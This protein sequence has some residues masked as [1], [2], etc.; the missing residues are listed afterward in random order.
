MALDRGSLVRWEHSRHSPAQP[1]GS[2]GLGPISP[3][4]ARAHARQRSGEPVSRGT[5]GSSPA[6]DHGV[7]RPRGDRALVAAARAVFDRGLAA[8]CAGQR[9]WLHGDLHPRNVLVQ[10]GCIAAVIDWGDVTAGDAAT[11]LAAVWW[12]F[13]LEAHSDFWAAYGAS[14]AATW[15]RARAWAVIFGLSFLNRGLAHDPEM[16][17]VPAQSLAR[18]QLERV[19]APQLPPRTVDGLTADVAPGGAA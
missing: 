9:V 3:R 7:V 14:R 19:I 4:A 10:D 17:D 18:V 2:A 5:A 1:S 8:P 16:A 11:D 15:H 12:L 13:N 6:L